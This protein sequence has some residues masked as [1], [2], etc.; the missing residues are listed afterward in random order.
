[1]KNKIIA[2]TR[3]RAN[4]WQATLEYFNGGIQAFPS[5]HYSHDAA[6]MAAKELLNVRFK[7]PKSCVSDP[8]P[9]LLMEL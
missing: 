5:I 8:Q 4:G 3:C 7:Y 9:N 6:L 1:M 2:S